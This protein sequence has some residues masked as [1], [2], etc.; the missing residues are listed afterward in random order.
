M[1]RVLI[2]GANSYIGESV[3]NYLAQS[4][5]NYT[6]DTKDTIGWIPKPSDFVG[7]DVVFNV[8][9]IAHIKETPKNRHLYYAINKE[10]VVDIAKAAKAGGVRQFVLLSSM[11][12]YGLEIGR[13]TKDTNPNPITAYGDSK[14]GA[15]EEIKKIED[16]CFKFACLR[17]PMVYGKDCKG[18]YQRLRSF[19]LKAPIFPNYENKRSM[20]YIGNL[21]EFVK[22][23]I[24]E[25]RRGVFFPQNAEYTNTSEMVRTIAEAHGKKIRLTK[26]FNWAIKVCYVGVVKKVFGDL[27]YEQV[28]TIG[29]YGFKESIRLSEE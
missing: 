9:G 20:I 24:D 3:R 10:L 17:P 1:K 27:E 2:T 7:Y 23:T 14:L 26:A 5:D 13:I 16:T 12:V 18:N 8:A 6:V 29:K 21:C 15:D 28:D 19:A 25:E 4:P 22:D 11:S